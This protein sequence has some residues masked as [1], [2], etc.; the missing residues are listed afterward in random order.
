MLV[1]FGRKCEQNFRGGRRGVAKT[2][3]FVVNV[4]VFYW[5]FVDD[6]KDSVFFSAT[7]FVGFAKSAIALVADEAE[8][9]EKKA[10]IVL[11]FCSV[12]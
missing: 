7:E 2:H 3:F 9:I 1:H 5:I 11:S 12:L 6:L 4:S 10:G 8:Y